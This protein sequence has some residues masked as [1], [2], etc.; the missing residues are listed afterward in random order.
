M[1]ASSIYDNIADFIAGLNPK[2]VLEMRP[3][4]EM[5]ARL[6]AL[7]EKESVK[8]LSTEEKE[9]LDHYIILE[10]LIRLAKSRAI[11]RLNQP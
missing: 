3:E 1:T 7:M 2:N 4:P 9:E 5:Q 11:L 10:R 8:G 6:E